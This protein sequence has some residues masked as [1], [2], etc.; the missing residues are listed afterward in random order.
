[1][2]VY[3][4]N[5][6]FNGQGHT[7]SGLSINLPD[8]D[9]IGLF[10]DASSTSLLE[11]ISLTN[12]SVIGRNFVGGL[13]GY[14]NGGTVQT[15]GSTG[16]IS[17]FQEIGG[18]VG[19]NNGGLVQTCY[20][21]DTVS[22]DTEGNTV[23]GL[24]GGNFG[25]VETSYAA[26]AV[27]GNGDADFIGGLVGY[28]E[29]S[30]EASYATGAVNGYFYVGGLVGINYGGAVEASCASGPVNGYYYVGGL[31]GDNYGAVETSQATGAVDGFFYVGG[32]VGANFSLGGANDGLVEASYASGAVTT[33][34]S[35]SEYIGGLVGF[36]FDTVKTSYSTGQVTGGSN[37]SFVGGLVGY[38][39]GEVEESY[40]SGEASGFSGVGG[41]VGYSAS[42]TTT[43]SFW[44]TTTSRQSTSAGGTG[45]P[46][47][48]L[49]SA[50]TY[51][52][53]GW[54]I[55]TDL[56]SNT[57]VIF[58]GQTR[59][60]LSMEYSTTITNAHQLQLVGLNSTTLAAD[61][62]LANNIDLSAITIPS[63]VWGTT[64]GS[65]EGFVPIGIG[66]N[67]SLFT[68]TFNGHGHTV[69]G[70]YIR[71]P[72]EYNPILTA[73]GLFGA[74]GEGGNIE[75]VGVTNLQVSGFT[76][77]GGLAGYNAGTI[78][79]AYSTGTVS[80]MDSVGGLVGYNLLGSIRND[81]SS[82]LVNTSGDGGG[83]VGFNYEGEIS[84]AY[85][86]GA[87]TGGDHIGG[88]VGGTYYG[89]ISNAYST[90]P[91]ISGSGD[92][93][94]GGL[95]GFNEYGAIN[96][97]YSTGMV[98]A[99]NG[100][101]DLGGLV[102]YSEAAEISNS[103]WD[104]TTSGITSSNGGV[105]GGDNSG[106]TGAT[107][108]QLQTQSFIVAN[109]SAGSWDFALGTGVWGI[110]GYTSTGLINNGLPYFQ[111]RYPTQALV[112]PLSQS[113]TYPGT[114]NQSAYT[115]TF[116]PGYTSLAP[117][118]ASG[119][120]LSIATTGD[121]GSLP[122]VAV[123]LT[124]NTGYTIEISTVPA[125]VNSYGITPGPP[126]PP[127]PITITI[128][129]DNE[130][131]SQFLDNFSAQFNANSGYDALFRQSWFSLFDATQNDWLIPI[132]SLGNQPLHVYSMR[133][134][135]YA[136]RSKEPRG[137]I[138]FGSSF[139]TNDKHSRH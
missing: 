41:L 137:E 75:N 35:G 13:V 126:T 61:Y 25:L 94:V 37:S 131:L 97:A 9:N 104:T 38:N 30:V 115:T 125:T 83:L 72:A 10:S 90:G 18:L 4:D 113:V 31:V 84:D 66:N 36:N 123:S 128:Q 91:V 74:V 16:T 67:T 80:G 2:E 23:G 98:T 34:G 79:N 76:G 33:G 14:D 43:A 20:S 78:T 3:I 100:S 56:S 127:M 120:T 86:T 17:G 121:L 96:N 112:T 99:G 138:A 19:F 49:L 122:H 119:P 65:G 45:D 102:G 62:T 124:P 95:V 40:S 136:G 51:S 89:M 42:G 117:L 15:S 12:E 132:F 73:V 29:G 135:S 8:T 101:I 53:A 28:N 116:A 118:L 68:G 108:A 129:G 110:N 103:F 114:L 71:V 7:I 55:G 58:D 24:V 70:L 109:S 106:V 5:A 50:S 27:S 85:S 1:L 46:T 22:G 82:A 32:L 105:N 11:N 6:T 44:D 39:E 134:T 87:V 26:G 81:Y 47:A 111:W 139:T 54:N 59:P 77:V 69:D 64:L 93:S 107:T 48:T 88:L 21:T 133:G 92:N 52:N 57:W 130:S 60:M 63:D